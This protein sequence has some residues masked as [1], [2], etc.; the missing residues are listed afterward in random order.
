MNKEVSAPETGN[1]RSRGIRDREGN[2]GQSVISGDNQRKTHNWGKS[3]DTLLWKATEIFSHR[4]KWSCSSPLPQ[5]LVGRK[6]WWRCSLPT[7]TSTTWQGTSE[8]TQRVFLSRAGGCSLQPLLQDGG[9]ECTRWVQGEIPLTLRI[10]SLPPGTFPRPLGM[11]APG[12]H[13]YWHLTP[14][15]TI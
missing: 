13:T 6:R 7:S 14:T 4:W 12:F 15:Y 5:G 2:E 1:W 10:A 8:L 9:K 11:W 3:R